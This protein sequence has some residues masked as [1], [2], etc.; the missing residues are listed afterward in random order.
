MYC[1]NLKN[2]AD[3]LDNIYEDDIRIT[4][5]FAKFLFNSAYTASRLNTAIQELSEES[6]EIALK[7]PRDEE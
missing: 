6:D 3:A 2:L 7:Y 5:A 1:E 4:R